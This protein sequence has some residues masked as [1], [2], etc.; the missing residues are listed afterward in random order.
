MKPLPHRLFCFTYT[1]KQWLITRFTL[2]G[3]GFLVFLGI[4]AIIGIDTE[5][6]MAYQ[7]FTFLLSILIIAIIYS[8]RFSDRIIVSRILPRFGTVGVKLQYSITVHNRTNKRQ[9]GLK[10]RESFADPRPSWSKFKIFLRSYPRKHRFV[11]LSI[12]YYRWL[13]LVARQQKATTKT[14]NIPPIPPRSK[15][16]VMVELDPSH[17]GIVRLTGVTIARP[18]PFGLFNACQNIT[19]PQSFLILPKRYQVPPLQLPGTRKAQSG[20]ISLASSVGDSEEFVGLRDYRPG[21]P[22]RKI[23]WKSWAKTDKPIVREEQEQFFVRHALILDTFQEAKYSEILEEAISVASSFAC[24]FQTQES[25]LDLMFVAN[26]AYC[27]TAGRGLGTTEQMLEILAGVTPCNDVAFESLISTVVNRISMVSGCICV[28]IAWDEE[29]KKLIE[30][31]QAASIP[32]LV[33]IISEENSSL[34]ESEL[35]GNNLMQF[36]LLKLG[37]IQEELLM[38]NG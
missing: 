3:L 29:R 14:V 37:N 9:I 6:T 19:L 12:M 16:K 2:S 17:R 18:D 24:D 22:L 38:I 10:L 26:E 25:L 23:H 20:S 28:L 7:I 21:D 31:L 15:V 34:D 27:F 1:L 11:S 8:F 32:T 36:K 13:K 33:L 30:Y 5:R 4:T 35:I